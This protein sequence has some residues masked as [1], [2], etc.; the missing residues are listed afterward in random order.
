MICQASRRR[1]QDAPGKPGCHDSAVPILD[2][3]PTQGTVRP[4]LPHSFLPQPG[5]TVDDGRHTRVKVLVKR[6]IS[7]SS[8]PAVRSLGRHRRPP[9]GSAFK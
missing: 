8:W 2:P 6:D 4:R 3:P 9:Q 1:F 7:E 5:H